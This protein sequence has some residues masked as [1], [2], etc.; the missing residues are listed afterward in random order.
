MTQASECSRA[1]R[2]AHSLCSTQC[3]S[4]TLAW[5]PPEA[6]PRRIAPDARQR[7]ARPVH[8]RWRC[9]IRLAPLRRRPLP[10]PVL[11][12]GRAPEVSTTR[13]SLPN[14]E[15]AG[16]HQRAQ[17]LCGRWARHTRRETGRY[18]SRQD[19]ITAARADVYCSRALCN[20]A[21]RS[22]RRS[23]A[24]GAAGPA[25]WNVALVA[26]PLYPSGM[27][28]GPCLPSPLN[29]LPSAFNHIHTATLHWLIDC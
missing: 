23:A 24:H 27:S 11:T 7:F 25:A 14:D 26:R 2:P 6:M 8:R 9:S 19:A 13:S 22:G 18:G 12:A 29:H 21:P 20:V 4:V 28:D 3:I 10:E 17:R 1:H 16:V 5:T 15:G